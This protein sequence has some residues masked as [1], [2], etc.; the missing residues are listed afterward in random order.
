MW[1]VLAPGKSEALSD[2]L[3]KYAEQADFWRRSIMRAMRNSEFSSVE[4]ARID[5]SAPNIM[6]A[7][8][9]SE[10]TMERELHFAQLVGML[11]RRSRLI[12][13]VAA[14]GGVLAGAVGLLIPPRYTA[15]A[16]LIV[17]SQQVDFVG[18]LS[19]V[20]RA[21]DESAIDT[22]VTMLS[23]REHLQQVLDSLSREPEFQT[24]PEAGTEPDVIADNPVDFKPLTSIGGEGSAALSRS[25]GDKLSVGELGRRLKVWLGGPFI[26]RNASARELDEVER[27]LKVMQERRSRVISVSFTAT[28]PERAAAIANRVVELHVAHQNDEKRSQA[29]QELI[30][31]Q[32]R[33]AEL[34]TESE[35]TGEAMQKSLEQ[36][37]APGP[38]S[39]EGELRL[40]ELEQEA[41]VNGQTYASLLQRQIDIRH[42]QENIPPDAIILSL[43]T[44]PDRPSSPNPILFIFPALI[45]SSICGSLL[46]VVK[47][48]LDRGLRSERDVSDALGIPCIGLVPQLRRSDLAQPDHS[49]LSKPFAPYTEAMRSVAATL[50][51]TATP[52]F[53]MT[54]L[55]SSSVPREGKTTTAI[56]LSVYAAHLGKRV[57]LVDF[58]FRHPS[59]LRRLYGEPEKVVPDVQDR[60]PEQLV[61]H[62]RDLNLDYLPMPCSSG[63]PLAWFTGRHAKTLM[64]QLRDS[65]DC[66]FIDGPPLMGITE[67]R[68]LVPFADKCLFVIKWGSTTREVVQNA[69]NLLNNSLR[70]EKGCAVQVSALLT[71]VNLKTQAGYQCGDVTEAFT[72]YRSYYF[73]KSA[74]A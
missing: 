7:R 54:V 32:A 71:Q 39:R 64:R 41:A 50:Q 57:L 72:K 6:R 35:R 56:S 23:S 44:P 70:S 4:L 63:D 45:V 74:N 20:A 34:K 17:E 68:L 29:S 47:E 67:A 27:G 59:I 8:R 5:R 22:Q 3:L 9:S 62:L 55:I 40:R 36:R 73:R 21:T 19:A 11:R 61:H 2:R 25:P 15:T 31:I 51:L 10:Q 18:G 14:I 33:T 26:T 42:Q 28:S 66:V 30:R 49:L 48:R 24:T 38:G 13:T 60:P 43:A 46:A 37:L 16:Q 58:D 69:L 52:L 53:P 12:V 1:A 65:Y